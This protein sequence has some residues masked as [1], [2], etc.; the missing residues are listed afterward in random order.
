[1]VPRQGD[2]GF[3]QGSIES[4]DLEAVDRELSAGSADVARV[5][6]LFRQLCAGATPAASPVAAAQA[7]QLVSKHARLLEPELASEGVQVRLG[8]LGR[9]APRHTGRKE[10]N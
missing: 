6:E 4:M 9:K 2:E 5:E 7:C 1:M 10:G 3:V 8:W